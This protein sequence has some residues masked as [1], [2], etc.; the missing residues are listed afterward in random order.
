MKKVYKSFCLYIRYQY[1]HNVNLTLHTVI[2]IHSM[3]L[4]DKIQLE[5]R[6]QDESCQKIQDTRE[7]EREIKLARKK[8]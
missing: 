8:V 5:T 3:Q 6:K 7:K 4:K 1:F 2:S